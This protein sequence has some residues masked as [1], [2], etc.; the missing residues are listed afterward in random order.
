MSFYDRYAMCCKERG[1]LPTSQNVIDKIGCSRSYIS[2]LSK[3]NKIPSGEIIR[4][5]SFFFNVSADYLLEIID[6]PLPI[7]HVFSENELQILSSFRELNPEG[8]SA[9]TAML[10]GLTDQAIYKN[11]DKTEQLA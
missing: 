3:T 9:A 10:N 7:D 2:T 4:N 8:Q 5:I 1:V 11:S 6:V